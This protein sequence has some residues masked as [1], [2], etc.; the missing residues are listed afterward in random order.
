M[1]EEKS[2]SKLC[3]TFPDFPVVETAPTKANQ[4]AVIT[5]ECSPDDEECED[6]D[7]FL[8][9]VKRT[10]KKCNVKSHRVDAL[11]CWKCGCGFVTNSNNNTAAS[12]NQMEEEEAF[13]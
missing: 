3:F 6:D 13:T 4:F 11:F 10:C 8:L 9:D 12:S 2:K 5:P 7:D 1:K